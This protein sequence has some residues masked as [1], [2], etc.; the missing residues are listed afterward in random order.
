MTISRTLIATVV[1]LT[2]GTFPAAA[3]DMSEAIAKAA[4]VPEIPAFLPDKYTVQAADPLAID[5]VWMISSLRKKI[6]ID[7]GRAY[8]VD[9]WLHMFVLR[10]MPDMV[11]MQNMRRTGEGRYEADDLPLMGPA[12]M[13]L[14]PK[15]NLNVTVQGAFGP[16]KYGLVRLEA[17]YPEELSSEVHAATG[18][19]ISIASAMPVS[20]PVL[21]TTPVYN[22]PPATTP[23]P[24]YNPPPP[25]AG[26]PIP[27]DGSCV[28]IGVDPDTGATICAD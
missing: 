6:R 26:Q 10:V 20:R 14:D 9:P 4:G 2:A 18:Q 19:T 5:G 17:L 13:D 28:A 1:L 12:V 25:S 21:P 16:V 15:G 22:P 8:A 24:A 7:Q 23:P 3:Q 11:V 27:S